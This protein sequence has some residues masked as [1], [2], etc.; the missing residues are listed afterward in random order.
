[1][2]GPATLALLSP[3]ALPEWVYPPLVALGTVVIATTFSIGIPADEAILY[4]WPAFY[5]VYFFSARMAVA[6]F[7]WILIC[8]ATML[9]MW[10][11]PGDHAARLVNVGVSLGV[12]VWLVTAMRR[13]LDELVAA[14]ARRTTAATRCAPPDP[15]RLAPASRAPWRRLLQARAAAS[16][17]AISV[18]KR[19]FSA[20]VPTDTRSAPGRPSAEPARTSTPP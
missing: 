20:G 13:R 17:A 15:R 4:L 19:S 9:T 16:C 5:A 2:T 8:H 18:R 14:L 7:V 6:Q 3:F 11:L 12:G 1:V 10:D